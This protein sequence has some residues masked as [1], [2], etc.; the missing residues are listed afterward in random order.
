MTRVIIVPL[1]YNIGNLEFVLNK[2]ISILYNGTVVATSSDGSSGGDNFDPDNA[3]TTFGYQGKEYFSLVNT[4]CEVAG[5]FS[6]I[7]LY[8]L[9]N[10]GVFSGG[11]IYETNYGPDVPSG[12]NEIVGAVQE[13]GKLYIIIGPGPAYAVFILDSAGN[14][15]TIAAKTT[16]GVIS[17]PSTV[18]PVSTS[19]VPID[20]QN[21]ASKT[22]GYGAC[23][24][25][26]TKVLMADGS[27]KNV[28]DVRAGDLVASFDVTTGERI[29]AS[30]VSTIQRED[31]I[32]TINGVL[33]AAPD[34][35]LYVADGETKGAGSLQ[36]G[37]QLL[38]EDG[39]SIAVS[40]ITYS[41]KPVTT[42]DLIL[43]NGQDFFASG[44][45]VRSVPNETPN[46]P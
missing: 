27:Y 33:E 34:E 7:S 10:T 42:Y 6:D 45:L 38:G 5:C 23:L 13:N 32:I 20:I 41:A 9:D 28:E 46:L 19:T 17:F 4:D 24:A 26:G 18:V 16:P 1:Q 2:G 29:A 36:M 12:P 43:Q 40:T 25:A 37:D 15:Q 3:V 11:H 8:S 14:L 31:P 39:K 22:T 30:V 21:I 35:M 44:Y